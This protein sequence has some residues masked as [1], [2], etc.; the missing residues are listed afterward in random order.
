[1]TLAAL[2]ARHGRRGH[3][4]H[5]LQ[6]RS[7]Y[8]RAKDRAGACRSTPTRFRGIKPIDDLV[9]ADTGE[10][11]LE[12]GKKMTPRLAR[13][14]AGKGPQGAAACPTRICSATISP[15]TSSIRRP[16]KSTPR[17]AS[18]IDREGAEGARSE[19]GYQRTAGARHRP[20]QRRPLHPQH[21]GGRQEH[22]AR[23]RAVRHLPRDAS[24]RAAD[25][26]HRGSRCSTSLFF[27]SERYDLS[28]VGRVKM[29]MRLDLD[30]P[31]THA[32]A[33]Q[34]RHPRRH[35]DAGRPARRQGRDRR[36]RPPR[37]P[38]RALGRR[39]DGEPVPR[40]PA[41]HGAR[42]QGAHVRRSISTPSCRRT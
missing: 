10:V 1:M 27:D 7:C 26:R 6:D 37:Q 15:R 38:P 39:T 17:P 30:A 4:G 14:L 34:G 3:P 9:D 36:H 13:Q 41:A 2:C 21:A 18:E 16:A 40:R 5:L 12:A 25:A 23:R 42:D 32:H 29:N 33:A 19:Q 31:D 22:D 8:K 35:Q 24:G 28:A 11:V 20:R